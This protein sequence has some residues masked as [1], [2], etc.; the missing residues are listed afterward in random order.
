MISLPIHSDSGIW[1]PEA[2]A[3]SAD[4]D[5]AS[6]VSNILSFSACYMQSRLVVALFESLQVRNY[7]RFSSVNRC[8]EQFITD[9]F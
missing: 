7:F 6:F 4:E 3:L 5:D 1:M 9:S 2:Y 8:C